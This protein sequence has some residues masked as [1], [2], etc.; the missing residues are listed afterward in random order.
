[1][2]VQCAQLKSATE[3]RHRVAMELREREQKVHALKAKF[4]TIAK[5][6]N[7]GGDDDDGEERSQAYYV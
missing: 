5:S 4:E 7:L 6:V 3:E 2:E 1:M